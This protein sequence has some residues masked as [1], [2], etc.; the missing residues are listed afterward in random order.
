MGTF[1]L[2]DETITPV[3]II[4]QVAAGAQMG[5]LRPSMAGKENHIEQDL[6]NILKL[7]WAED[8]NQR[9]DFTDLRDGLK[10]FRPGVQIGNRHFVGILGFS[11]N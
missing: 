10:H 1:Y 8:V 4:R 3:E 2:D 7:C 6:L 5:T 9:P 11:T